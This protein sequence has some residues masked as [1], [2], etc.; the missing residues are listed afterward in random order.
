MS[1]YG[2]EL[3]PHIDMVSEAP[4]WETSETRISEQEDVITDDREEGY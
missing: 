3:I 4:V 1:E 2:D